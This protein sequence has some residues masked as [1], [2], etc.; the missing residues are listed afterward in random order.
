MPK[1]EPN[2][3]SYGLPRHLPATTD[4]ELPLL[5]RWTD[6]KKDNFTEGNVIAT[7][8]VGRNVQGGKLIY[9]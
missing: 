9:F 1:P 8:L 5:L 4:E 3:I 6:D 2:N 7:D